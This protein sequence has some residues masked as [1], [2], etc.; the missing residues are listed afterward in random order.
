MSECAA[1]ELDGSTDCKASPCDGQ[2]EY[3][4][5]KDIPAKSPTVDYKDEL[6]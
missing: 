3:V 6:R 2:Y 5:V 4:T 1:Y